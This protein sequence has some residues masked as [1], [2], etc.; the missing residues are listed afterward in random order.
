MGSDVWTCGQHVVHS[1]WCCC[2]RCCL[3]GGSASLGLWESLS[4]GAWRHDL[5]A[6]CSGHWVYLLPDCPNMTNFHPHATISPNK[7]FRG[8]WAWQQMLLNPL[9]KPL[10]EDLIVFPGLQVNNFTKFRAVT[11]PV[12]FTFS[13]LVCSRRSGGWDTELLT[14]EGLG[15]QEGPGTHLDSL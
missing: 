1:Q 14:V 4:L 15:T 9:S 8:L 2:G 11:P 12:P 10:L 5:A 7:L 3:A 13:H 6:P